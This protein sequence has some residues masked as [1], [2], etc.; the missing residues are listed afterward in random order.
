MRIYG[1]W[2]QL[3]PMLM[4]LN[5]SRHLLIVCKRVKQ[6]ESSKEAC[7]ASVNCHWSSLLRLIPVALRI[8]VAIQ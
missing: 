2:A 1:V 3:E 4:S 8:G 5:F 7:C 6:F